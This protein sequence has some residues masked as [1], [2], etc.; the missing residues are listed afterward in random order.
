MTKKILLF[1][2]ENLL[3]PTGGPI[4]YL[5]NLKTVIDETG[6]SNI[7]FIKDYSVNNNTLRSKVNKFIGNKNKKLILNRILVNSIYKNKIS[8]A[9]DLSEY[10]IIHFHTTNSM[11]MNRENIKN[12]KG[13]VLLTTHSPKPAH[14]EIIE[15]QLSIKERFW[16]RK[17]LKSL[18]KI[19]VY[20]FNRA[21]HIIFPC[22]DAEEPYF[23]NWS[24]F[25][26]LKESNANKF[27]YIPTG[28]NKSIVKTTKE[29][30]RRTWNIPNESFVISYVGR[31]N[32][33][34]GYDQLKIIGEKLLRENDN[35]YF[36]IAGSEEPLKG[37][38]HERW[39]EVGWTNDPHSLIN[40]SD[41][42]LLPNK[43]TYFDLILLEVL[44]LGKLI[45]A[46]NTGGNKYFKRFENRGIFHYEGIDEA[47][48]NIRNIINM[49]DEQKLKLEKHNLEIYGN[50]FTM[51]IFLNNYLKILDE[52]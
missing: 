22:E 19:D 44:S 26:N 36:L 18:E 9:I 46:T 6:V 3:K 39:I 34:K 37:L 14:L 41:M 13:K 42:F 17:K 5:Y 49:D 51:Q 43:E 15:D 21:D 50:N 31:H 1:M 4:G 29:E 2:N 25:K 28:C 23:N 47:I 10:D 52:V 20:S 30:V 48:Q 24:R 8:K 40:A 33:T 7:E 27:K 16:Y 45:L 35:I 32:Q 38:E 12:F 11:F